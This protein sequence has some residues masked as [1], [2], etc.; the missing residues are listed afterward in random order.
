M[1][2]SKSIYDYYHVFIFELWL[3]SVDPCLLN[4]ITIKCH[5]ILPWP[6][7]ELVLPYWNLAMGKMKSKFPV[8]D[9]S[10]KKIILVKVK[11]C[12]YLCSTAS[13]T[14]Q[15]RLA[16]VYTTEVHCP[17]TKYIFKYFVSLCAFPNICVHVSVC[18]FSGLRFLELDLALCSY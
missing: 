12:G 9:G 3:L 8:M 4:W 2:C 17:S 5:K 18:V 13:Q 6:T 7:G 16:D 1:Y 14:S 11:A 10:W 15:Y